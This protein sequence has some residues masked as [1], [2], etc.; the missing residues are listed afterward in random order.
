MDPFNTIAIVGVGLMGGS[1][2]MALKRKTPNI[3]IFGVDDDPILKEAISFDAIDKGFSKSELKNCIKQT[4]LVFLCT[5]ISEILA[6]LPI[7]SEAIQPGTLVTD[8]GSTKREIVEAADR[9]F[10]KEKYFLG[11]HPM[12][13]SEGHGIRWADPLLFENAVYVLT[14]SQKIPTRLTQDFGNLIEDIGAKVIFLSPD[15][16]D[17]IAANVSHLPQILAVTLVNLMASHQKN[18]PLYSKLA[19]GGFRDMTRIVSSPYEIWK[20]I[21]QTNKEEISASIDEFIEAL[22]TTRKKLQEENLAKDFSEAFRNRLSIPRDTKGFLRPHYDLSVRVEDRPGVIASISN[23]LSEK[24]INIKDIE[25]IKVREN[26]LGTLRLSFASQEDRKTAQ[27]LL[28][29]IGY[30][31]R[32][33]D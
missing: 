13:G 26:D 4:H 6:S 1:L 9:Y 30:S 14:P 17:K 22:K 24:S 19:A 27:E 18:F 2:A 28:T 31:S 10:Q 5:P 12:A 20:D 15:M 33:R 3:Q 8:V 25:I 23:T 11:G 29:Q 32:L 21:F 7:V 16:H